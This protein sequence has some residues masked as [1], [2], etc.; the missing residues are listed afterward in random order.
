MSFDWI[1][2]EHAMLARACPRIGA[3]PLVD[4]EATTSTLVALDRSFMSR[5]RAEILGDPSYDGP[6]DV[7]WHHEG[8]EHLLRLHGADLDPIPWSVLGNVAISDREP[9]FRDII[10][11]AKCTL[12]RRRGHYIPAVSYLPQDLWE[13][14]LS[15][16]EP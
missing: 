15:F 4:L 13:D 7:L 12:E 3:E 2:F 11:D 9:T 14:I 10:R 5:L 6:I 16:N 8:R 1:A